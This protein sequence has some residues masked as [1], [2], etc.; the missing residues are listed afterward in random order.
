ME[1]AYLTIK[2]VDFYGKS[3]NLILFQ[4][5]DIPTVV[6]EIFDKWISCRPSEEE[7]QVAEIEDVDTRLARLLESQTLA[8]TVQRQYTPDEL[9]IREAVLAQY[10]QLSDEVGYN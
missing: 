2:L 1:S 10:S 7:S 4:L 5:S 3:I 6:K 9:R 8:T